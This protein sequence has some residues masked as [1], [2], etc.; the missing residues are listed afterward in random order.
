LLVVVVEALKLAAAAVQ[1]DIEQP[2]GFLLLE[3]RHIPLLWA[4][5]AQEAYIQ[6][7]I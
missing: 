2:Q 7:Q 5:G 6:R 1:V 4:A 3:V